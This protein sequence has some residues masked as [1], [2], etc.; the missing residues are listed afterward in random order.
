LALIV[1]SFDQGTFLIAERGEVVFQQGEQLR[2]G[3]AI[4]AAGCFAM[5]VLGK[6]AKESKVTVLLSRLIEERG[7]G[8]HGEPVPEARLVVKSFDV[9]HDADECGL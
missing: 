9:T 2:V 8:Q 4:L 1:F 3:F 6:T 5:C 7:A